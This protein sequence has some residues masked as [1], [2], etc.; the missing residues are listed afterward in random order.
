KQS[1]PETVGTFS[2]Y[3]P[4]FVALLLGV[5]IIVGLLPFV[6]AAALG[7]IVAHLLM[8]QGKTY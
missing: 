4:I 6:P 1:V 5:I 8:L 3:S 7:P 2:T